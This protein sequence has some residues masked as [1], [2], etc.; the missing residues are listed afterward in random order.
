MPHYI[1]FWC[2]CGDRYWTTGAVIAT[3]FRYC[4]CRWP[5]LPTPPFSID[6][7]PIR[8]WRWYADW[9]KN[10]RL[11]PERILVWADDDALCWWSGMMWVPMPVPFISLLLFTI[12][13]P[14]FCNFPRWWAIRHA[15]LI[16][17]FID[18]RWVLFCRAVLFP[19]RC[20]GDISPTIWVWPWADPFCILLSVI[21]RFPF[22]RCYDTIHYVVDTTWWALPLFIAAFCSIPLLL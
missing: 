10:Y 18:I 21:P 8:Y 12:S 5:V 4:N 2:R 6:D 15:G 9:W 3:V 17:L 7:L 14:T 1:W 11:W 13:L 20:G 19:T 16:R 22:Y